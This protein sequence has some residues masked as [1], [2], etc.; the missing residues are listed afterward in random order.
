MFLY[1][2]QFHSWAYFVTL[3]LLVM[4]IPLSRFTM[5]V[6]QFTLLGLWIWS[7]FSFEI[8][9]RFF[10]KQ[11]FFKGL[12]YFL[13][14]MLQLTRTNFIEKFS[15]F[16]KNRLAVIVASLFLLHMIGLIHTSD[17]SYALKDLRTKL[18]LLLLP[19]VFS[20]MEKISW[21]KV[22]ILLLFYVGS[23]FIG[24]M[25]G[26]HEYLKQEFTDIRQISLF[27]NPIRFGLNIVFAIFILFGQVIFVPKTNKCLTLLF[28]L[29]IV[30]F[31]TFL[32]MIESAIGLI[33]LFV[34]FIG[35]LFVKVFMIKNKVLRFGVALLLIGLPLSGYL[36]LSH[37]VKEL[38]TAPHIDPLTLET[39]TRLGNA[40][41]HDTIHFGL[42]EGKYVGLYLAEAELAEAWNKRSTI[43]FYGRDEANQEIKYTLIR[44]LTSKDL[45]K[46]AEGLGMLSE[47]EVRMV[48][49]GIANVHYVTEPSIKTRMSKILLGYRLYADVNDPNGSSVMQRI[50]YLK[51]SY[52]IVRDNFWIGVGTGDLPGIFKD[53]YEKMQSPLKM[54]WRW[55]SHN[56]YLSIFIAFGIFGFSWFLCTIFYPFFSSKKYRGYHYTIFIALILLSMLT[57]DTIESQDGVTLFAF[58]NAFFLFAAMNKQQESESTEVEA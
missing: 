10:R 23:V 5:S 18:P 8:S 52:I 9:F 42:E 15:L 36:Y 4:S 17:F 21:E 55:R 57:E 35:L 6:F 11:G 14:Y 32:V 31:V 33:S 1:T 24:T 3:V 38:T 12:Y 58:F 7:G 47:K 49:K 56:Q 2:R 54:Q 22:R 28:A 26:L 45:R 51:A 19:V 20:T 30:W 39:H 25:F 50:E 34:I 43:D 16:F 46:D 53:T 41:L 48:E 37:M 44:F 29:L 40:Y 27:I 13:A